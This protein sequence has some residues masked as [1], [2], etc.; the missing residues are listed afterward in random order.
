MKLP[1][2]LNNNDL[3]Q[4]ICTKIFDQFIIQPSYYIKK[5]DKISEIKLNL[6]QQMTSFY[7]YNSLMSSLT[8]T[9]EISFFFLINKNIKCILKLCH[10]IKNYLYQNFIT[11]PSID[12][13][14]NYFIKNI[15]SQIYKYH[16]L[17]CNL[18]MNLCLHNK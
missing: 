14:I 15:I 10:K 7:K 12:I 9:S 3:M 11:I 16:Y 5:E 2:N 18:D 13:K 4:N 1:N 8:Y 6:N 17:S